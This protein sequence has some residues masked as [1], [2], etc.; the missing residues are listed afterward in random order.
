M[1]KIN[2]THLPNPANL[3][4]NPAV[5]A[6]FESFLKAGAVPIDPWFGVANDEQCEVVDSGNR[7]LIT[8]NDT[9]YQRYKQVMRAADLP[10][11]EDTDLSSQG[12]AVGDIPRDARVLPQVLRGYQPEGGRAM[13]EVFH[14]I[15]LS[16]DRIMQ[17]SRISPSAGSIALRR[18]LVLRTQGEVL[19]VPPLKFEPVTDTTRPKLVSQMQAQLLPEYAKFGGA[20]LLRAFRAGLENDNS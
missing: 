5:A 19:L 16:L 4:A 9:D 20:T 10:C 2:S 6:R 15:G 14:K 7:Y 18:I 1:N 11:L 17:T 12:A 8:P 13:Q 3:P